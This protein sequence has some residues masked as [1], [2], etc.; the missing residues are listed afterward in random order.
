MIWSQIQDRASEQGL[1]L[2]TV[3][4]EV[5]HLVVLDALFLTVES[6]SICFQGGTSIHLLH[7]GYRYSEDLDFAG[8]DLDFAKADRMVTGARSSIEKGIVQMLGLGEFEWK[9]PESSE[10]RNVAAYWIVFRPAGSRRKYRVKLEFA[11]YPFYQ[12]QVLPILSDFD[13]FQRRLLVTGLA[14]EEL[15]A[16]KITAVCG[17]S[18]LKGR[19]LF[20]LWYLTQ[21]LRSSIDLDLLRK[22]F[23]DYRDFPD[24]PRVERRLAEFSQRMFAAEMERFLPRRFRAQLEKDGYKVIRDSAVRMI[25]NVLS[26]SLEMW[27]S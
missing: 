20:D 13:V 16:E 21:V 11:R 3:V 1:P 8:H 22:K 14:P 6:R 17:R 19:D 15:L 7:G 25:R 10:H 18:Y 12:P 27:S 2:S 9:S 23:E 26:E 24:K 5:L 4:A